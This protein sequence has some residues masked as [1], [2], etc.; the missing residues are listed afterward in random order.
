MG[1]GIEKARHLHRLNNGTGEPV[2][3]QA[4]PIGKDD[5]KRSESVRKQGG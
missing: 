1:Y 4:K 5:W 3:R 2:R